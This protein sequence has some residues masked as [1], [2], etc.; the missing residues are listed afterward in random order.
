MLIDGV[1]RTLVQQLNICFKQLKIFGKVQPL[2]PTIFIHSQRQFLQKLNIFNSAR[3]FHSSPFINGRYGHRLVK[4]WEQP[5]YTTKPLHVYR[6]GGRLPVKNWKDEIVPGRV[7]TAKLGG[8]LPRKWYW[9]DTHRMT[10]EEVVAGAV[11]QEKIT[12]IMPDDNRSAFIA[13][14]A[15]P[16]KRRWILCTENMKV[17]DLVTNSAQ[18][19]ES[20]TGWTPNDGDAYPLCLLAIGTKVCSVEFFPGKGGQIARSAGAFCT[21]TKK[22]DDRV[23]LQM[24]S[25]REI[26]VNE[27]CVAVVGTVSNSNHWNE[28]W[29]SA[30]RRREYGL[31]PRTGRKHKND[32][33]FARRAMPVRA[34][35]IMPDKPFLQKDNNFEE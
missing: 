35:L 8:G 20:L 27:K 29:G 4:L 3:K 1:K 24:P 11:F 23:Q 18:L 16:V 26:V 25:K 33:R 14:V 5:E 12:K 31:R 32:G 17:G 28:D 9:V 22:F 10:A 6:T 19:T 34:P 7:W 21:I 2:S 30:F 13:L 15:G